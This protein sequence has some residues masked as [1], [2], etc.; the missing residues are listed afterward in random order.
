MRTVSVVDTTAPTV[1]A[2]VASP[3]VIPVPDHKMVDVSLTYSVSDLSGLVACSV[4]VTSS[5]PINGVGDGHTTVDYQVLSPTAV[6]V[7]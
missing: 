5:E 2:I 7:R 4:T 6:A 3:S 1:N